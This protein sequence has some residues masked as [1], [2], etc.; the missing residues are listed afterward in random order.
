MPRGR[1]GIACLI[2]SVMIKVLHSV[3]ADNLLIL[4]TNLSI[5]KMELVI[6]GQ[7]RGV[8]LPR[9]PVRLSDHSRRGEE[10]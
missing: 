5:N 9:L 10:F 3:V 2:T 1:G 8:A 7:R 4:I 6:Q